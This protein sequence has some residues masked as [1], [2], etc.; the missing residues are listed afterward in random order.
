MRGDILVVKNKGWLFD[1][2]RTM[3]QADFDHVALYVTDNLIVEATPTAGVKIV[4]ASKYTGQE[5]KVLELLPGNDKERLIEFALMKVGTGYDWL[6]LIALYLQVAFSIQRDSL[7]IPNAFLC[8]ELLADG[9]EY[10]GFSFK[11]GVD[12]DR[13]TPADIISS[14]KVKERT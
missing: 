2:I 3:I 11:E 10:A 5:K 13:L 1:K 4:D 8:V 14:D 12:K 9:A 7:D 6:N